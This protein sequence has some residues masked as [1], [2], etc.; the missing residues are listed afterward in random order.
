MSA[1]PLLTL[2]TNP[3]TRHQGGPIECGENYLTEGI[4]VIVLILL[5]ANFWSLVKV[6]GHLWRLLSDK[7]ELR[8]IVEF[9]KSQGLVAEVPAIRPVFGSYADNIRVFE[10]AHIATF[11]RTSIMVAGLAT[12]I[13]IGTCFLGYGYLA[14]GIA[15]FVLPAAF[16]LV[17]SARDQN[18]TH[19][20]TVILNLL[21]WRDV[22]PAGVARYCE[23]ET[24]G[25]C[26][27]ILR[28]WGRDTGIVLKERVRE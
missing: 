7:Y 13:L 6:P 19:L 18:V 25:I 3:C 26:N 14:V 15:F 9:L 12:A 1:M 4:V 2:L 11:R 17:A 5:A 8:R 20:H 23:E 27:A 28:A 22:E 10:T 24:A 21:K 16:P